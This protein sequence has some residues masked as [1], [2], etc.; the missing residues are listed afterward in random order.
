M[1]ACSDANIVIIGSAFSRRAL[2]L[3]PGIVQSPAPEQR[4]SFAQGVCLD[5]APCVVRHRDNLALLEATS[6]HGPRRVCPSSPTLKHTQTQTQTRGSKPSIRNRRGDSERRR[7]RLQSYFLAGT[8][9]AAG[10]IPRQARSADSSSHRL[11]RPSPPRHPA[12]RKPSATP[13][14]LCPSSVLRRR[15][16]VSALFSTKASA[17]HFARVHLHRTRR[18]CDR[19]ATITTLRPRHPPD[20][21]IH[22]NYSLSI[23][24]ATAISTTAVFRENPTA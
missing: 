21:L 7:R 5:H 16:E 15:G 1:R 18:L 23:P 24:V 3:L 13:F 9:L 8:R 4:L 11:T 20:G 22:G 19:L 2:A 14:P 12:P 17:L 10:C 6:R